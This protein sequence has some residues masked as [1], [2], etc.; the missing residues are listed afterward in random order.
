MD[1]DLVKNTSSKAGSIAT[2]EPYNFSYGSTGTTHKRRVNYDY[3]GKKDKNFKKKGTIEYEI[4]P[5][6]FVPT[7]YD[8]YL[9]VDIDENADMFEIHKDIVKCCGRTPRISQENRGRLLIEANSPEE[10][11]KLQDLSALGGITVNCVPHKSLNQSKGIVYAPQLMRYSEDRLQAEFEAQGI[12]KVERMKKKIDDSLIPQPNL[13]LTFDSTVLPEYLY[14]AW[15][16]IKVKPFIP[17]PRRCFYCQEFG[18]VLM[19]CRVKEQGKPAVCRNCGEEEHGPCF[20]N[21]KCIHCGGNHPS[22]STECEVFL[23]ENEIQATRTKERLSFSEAKEKVLA[24][25]IRPE[26]IF[27][28][29]QV[30]VHLR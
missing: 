13:I 10:S 3:K 14:A 20:E 22:S 9:T 24:K 21:S 26:M 25:S 28:Q 8:K 17:K 7:N 2:L 15:H 1:K 6:L 29:Q 4:V 19:S 18:H 30:D 5:G 27:A 12:C 16:K 23:L 11:V